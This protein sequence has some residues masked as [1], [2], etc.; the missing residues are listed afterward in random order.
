MKKSSRYCIQ[1][2]LVFL[3]LQ[4]MG[5]AQGPPPGAPGKRR[6]PGLDSGPPP[7]RPG[8]RPGPPFP[9]FEIFSSNKVVKG[10][11]YSATAVTES[12]QTLADGAKITNKWS[13][14]IY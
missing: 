6:P 5:L 12:V 2:L 7:D 10:A 1:F 14:D 8:P 9:P 4:L 11:P 13:D 3:A